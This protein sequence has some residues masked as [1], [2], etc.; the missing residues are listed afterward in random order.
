MWESVVNAINDR[1]AAID[2][3]DFIS[4]GIGIL[5]I[6]IVAG[7]AIRTGNFIIARF[8]TGRSGKMNLPVEERR[9]KTLASIL[10]SILRY[11]V[12]FIAGMTILDTLGVPMTSII[13]TAGI[14][15]LAV[16]FGAQNLVKD[17]ITGFFI[18][19][20][21]QISVGDYVTIEGIS[22]TV[23][24][25]GLRVTTIQG[26][27]GELNIIPNGSIT[28][29][30]NYSRANNKAIVDASI[31]YESDMDKAISIMK[32]VGVKLMEENQDIVEEPNVLGV[33]SLGESGITIRMITTVRPTTQWGVE[34]E[35]RK[36]IKEAFERE[37]IEIPY[38]RMV[39]IQKEA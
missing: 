19:L 24:G 14:G 4:K 34:R 29:V 20:E 2:F 6:L 39:V 8:V 22:G 25:I 23:T 1:I 38:P 27:T 12:Y 10:R 36:R 16:G 26:F 5:I 31:S 13:A 33:V 18:L 30:V 3:A 21:D 35:L 11:T 17:V 32:N 37:G 15:G 9:L 28:K 7:I